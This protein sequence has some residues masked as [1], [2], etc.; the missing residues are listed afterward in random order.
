[1]SALRCPACGKLI[2]Q[3][4]QETCDSCKAP[5]P[6]A[7]A[8]APAPGSPAPAA[9]ALS[10]LETP[11]ARA[12]AVHACKKCQAPNPATAR[13]CHSCGAPLAAKRQLDDSTKSPLVA[14]LLALL[15]PGLGY[16]YVGRISRAAGM[17]AVGL[18][19]A[20]LLVSLR[21]LPFW[22]ACAVLAV[23]RVLE[24]ADA[25]WIAMQP[26]EAPLEPLPIDPHHHKTAVPVP[27]LHPGYHP[28]K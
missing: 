7:D 27:A 26:G 3:H 13:V 5:L 14:L 28:E 25:S 18:I 20:G 1:M 11:S 4:G 23:S 8:A 21:D 9:A 12:R 10:P 2:A 19:G 16:F 17:L 24:L 6:K 22:I 15:F